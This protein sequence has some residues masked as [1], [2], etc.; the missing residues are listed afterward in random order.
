MIE[1]EQLQREAQSLQREAELL[2]AVY[3][4]RLD[5]LLRRL[6]GPNSE[7]ANANQLE[8]AYESVRNDE[9]IAGCTQPEPPAPSESKPPRKGG[10]RRAAPANLP[11]ERVVLDVPAGEREGCIQI[12]EEVTEEIDY[13]PSRFIRRHYVRPVYAHP[14]KLSAPVVAALP[15]RVIPQGSVGVGL[16]AHIVVSR[17]TDHLPFY[18]QE[19]IFARS[20]VQLDRQ[21]LS[22]WAEH[23]A[24]LLKGIHTQLRERVLATGYIQADETAVKLLDA[25]RP[26]AARDSWLWTYLAPGAQALVFDFHESRGRD[27]PRN[28]IPEDWQG[29]LQTDGYEL[30]RALCNERPQIVQAGCMAHARRKWVEAADGGGELVAAILADFALLYRIETEARERQLSPQERAQLRQ[31]RSEL[32]LAQLQQKLQR[33]RELAL[34]QSRMG[35]AAQYALGRWSVLTR[36]AQPGYGHVEIDNNPVENCIRPTALGKKNWLFIG[37]PDAGWKAAVL[38]SVLGTCKLLKINP[39]LY[40]AWV[41][42]KLAAATSTTAASGLLPH[43]Y[44]AIFKER[45]A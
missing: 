17:Y 33:A 39:E 24:L 21:K 27:S 29:V 25:E 23:V 38:Y 8:L 16:L 26:G 19:Q 30:Y 36:F 45:T 3:K 35:L 40:L 32:R 18:R 28:F 31:D 15:A 22:R 14:G 10:G 13:V 12:R 42:P 5:D 9:A 6:F 43:D 41:L 4:A 11:I 1:R 37:H 44:A 7:K 2:A 20:G 34:P